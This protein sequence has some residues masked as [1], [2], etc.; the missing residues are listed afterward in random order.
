MQK[1]GM[2]QTA[3]EKDALEID[4]KKFDRLIFQYSSH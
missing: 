3:V 2:K 4:G 1:A